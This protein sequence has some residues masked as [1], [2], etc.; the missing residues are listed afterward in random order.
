[1]HFCLL[2]RGICRKVASGKKFFVRQKGKKLQPSAKIN[3]ISSR[4]IPGQDELDGSNWETCLT[5]NG[6]WGYKSTNHKWKSTATLV[7]SLTDIA[8]KGGNYC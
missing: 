3:T 4:F 2:I 8:S 7:R 6:S 1:M 5:M